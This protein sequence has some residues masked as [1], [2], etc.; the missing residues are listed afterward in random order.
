MESPSPGGLGSLTPPACSV[1][2]LFSH[3]YQTWAHWYPP[4]LQAYTH[5]DEYLMWQHTAIQLPATKVYLYKVNLPAL[6][7]QLGQEPGPPELE[8][9][10]W[11]VYQ[12]PSTA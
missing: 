3:K 1:A 10:S 7:C 4:E 12:L 2:I 9:T 6:S 11:S 8:W 5:V